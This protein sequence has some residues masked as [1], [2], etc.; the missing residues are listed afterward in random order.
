MSW[1][2]FIARRLV[3]IAVSLLIVSAVIFWLMQVVPGDLA[4]TILGPGASA[5]QV[6]ALREQLGL[7]ASPGVRYWHWLRGAL[8]GQFG[9]SQSLQTPITPLILTRAENSLVLALGAALVMFPVSIVLGFIAG[10]NRDRWGDS[11]ISKVTVAVASLPEFLIAILVVLFIAL[12]LRW[13]P[14]TSF[15]VSGSPIDHPSTLVLPILTLALAASAYFIRITRASVAK[16]LESDYVL[17]AELKGLSRLTIMRR[18]VAPNALLPTITGGASYLGSLVGGLII[19][20]AVF[21]YPGLGLVI[22]NAAQTKDVALLQAAV[23]FVAAF[24]MIMVLLAD[25]LYMALDPRIRRT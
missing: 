16:V 9:E 1:I 14:A 25:L 8:Q 20:E 3:F 7:S 24:R 12:K 22:L 17:A 10:L 5:S 2:R 18:H 23:I 6:R 19:V 4:Q 21:N 13:L 15:E 11:L